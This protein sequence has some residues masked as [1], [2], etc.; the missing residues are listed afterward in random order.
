M[1]LEDF[2]KHFSRIYIC[3][4]HDDNEFSSIELPRYANVNYPYDSKDL[5]GDNDHHFVI[6][7]NVPKD[8]YYLFS[9]SQKD[10]RGLRSP[11]YDYCSVR[12]LIFG[13][14]Y[15]FEYTNGTKGFKQRDTYLGTRKNWAKNAKS[16]V[17]ID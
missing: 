9:F 15:F 8:G 11:N 3:K 10:K 12:F 14:P 4:Y 7:I 17:D 16:Y 1:A 6:K 5:N 13:G 2:E